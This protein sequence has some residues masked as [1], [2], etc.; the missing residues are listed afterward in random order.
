[1]TAVIPYRHEKDHGNELK[2][3]IRSLVK[4][5]IPLS[6]II[7]V[8]DAPDWYNGDYIPFADIPGRKEYSIYSKLM[9][10]QGEVLYTNDDYFALSPFD[11]SLPYYYD[12]KCGN[13]RPTDKTYKDLYRSCLPTWLNFDIHCP[14]I[15][16]TTKFYWDIDRPIKTY[17]GNQN[18]LTGTY[19]VDCKLRGELP[20]SEIKNRIKGRPF[21]STHENSKIGAM[22]KVLNEL[23]PEKSK[24]EL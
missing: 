2:Y 15:I 7:V 9:Q 4:Y 19:L 24:Y 23:F 13:K 18:N 1:M 21:F 17:Y 20:Y 10:A 5:F 22:P 12:E 14:M 8:G 3:A 6:K 16:D 11:Q